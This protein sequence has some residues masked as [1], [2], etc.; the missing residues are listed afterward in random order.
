M[1]ER[2]AKITTERTFRPQPSIFFP[3]KCFFYFIKKAPLKKAPLIFNY[4][5]S[6]VFISPTSFIVTVFLSGTSFFCC[7]IASA[8]DLKKLF[9]LTGG[10]TICFYQE[11]PGSRQFFLEGYRASHSGS[12]H[13][14]G[15]S[16]C[17]NHTVFSERY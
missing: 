7:C 3:K 5:F 15:P 12:K 11:F 10:G 9:L 1:I 14:P 8:T 13:R 2:F 17:L 4:C 6:G 16:V